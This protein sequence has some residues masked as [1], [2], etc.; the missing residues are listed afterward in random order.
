MK[1]YLFISIEDPPLDHS[2]WCASSNKRGNTTA[3]LYMGKYYKH[4]GDVQKLHLQDNGLFEHQPPY[5]D[6]RIN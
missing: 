1:G 5:V 2:V 4:F 6:L 3:K